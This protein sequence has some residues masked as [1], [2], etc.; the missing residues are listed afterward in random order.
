MLLEELSAPRVREWGM[1][2]AVAV[3]DVVRRFPGE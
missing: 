2:D 3:D 1:L